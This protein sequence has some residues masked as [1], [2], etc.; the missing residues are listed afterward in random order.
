MNKVLC[1]GFVGVVVFGL[2]GLL[3][4]GWPGVQPVTAAQPPVGRLLADNPTAPT[5]PVKL[6]FI[7]HSSGGFWLADGYGRLGIALRDNN[8]YV[9]ATNYGWT[10]NGDVIGDRTDIGN[11]WEW[12][13]GPSSTAYMPAV[14]AETGKNTGDDGDYSRLATDPGGENEIVV[15]KSC[16]PNSDVQDP[17]S[18]IPAIGANPLRGESYNSAYHT[19]ANAKGIYIDL[20]NYFAT[21]PDK[22]FVVITA[23][24]RA[25]GDGYAA[26]YGANARALNNWLVD[27]ANGWLSGYAG[28]NVAVFDYF[29]VLTGPDNHHRYNAGVI[30]HTTS[31]NNSSYYPTGDSHPSQAGDQKATTEFLPLLNIFYHRWKD[32]A[33]SG[34][35]FAREASAGQIISPARYLLMW[36]FVFAVG[37]A[38]GLNVETLKTWLAQFKWHLLRQR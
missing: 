26:G 14:Y 34:V 8:Y 37:M 22:L 19:L 21:R 3:G 11:W 24:P 2:G 31:A 23:P 7:H 28:N 10:V 16:Y 4:L 15:F 38:A 17:G 35:V 1:W 5:Q 9:S 33:P 30:E 27:T 12:F 32:G 36:I 6:V 13:R 20:L 29:T 18:P 25:V